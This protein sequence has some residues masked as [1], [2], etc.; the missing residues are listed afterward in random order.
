MGGIS[1]NTEEI[2]S[3]ISRGVLMK[4][5]IT[6]EQLR[7]IYVAWLLI[8]LFFVGLGFAKDNFALIEF[9]GGIAIGTSI[10]HL[11]AVKIYIKNRKT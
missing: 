9:G 8:S 5:Q 11:I 6:I 10:V 3:C 7:M 2:S 1:R 4:N